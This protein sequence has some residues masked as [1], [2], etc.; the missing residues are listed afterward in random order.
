[1]RGRCCSRKAGGL[2]GGPPVA[3]SLLNTNSSDVKVGRTAREPPVAVSGQGRRWGISIMVLGHGMPQRSA[4]GRRRDPLHHLPSGPDPAELIRTSR[5]G[6]AWRLSAAGG[7]CGSAAAAGDARRGGIRRQERA[8]PTLRGP[9]AESGLQPGPTG[10]ALAPRKAAAAASQR[11]NSPNSLFGTRLSAVDE[12]L[13]RAKLS[14]NHHRQ[15]PRG[16]PADVTG[17]GQ[18]SS[19]PLPR[20]KRAPPLQETQRLWGARPRKFP[21]STLA[22]W[23]S[24]IRGAPFIIPG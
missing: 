23:N 24:R 9:S 16:T 15:P 2:L 17:P 14:P 10:L 20:I 12:I 1:M 8:A 11:P 3:K 21:R 7:D 6:R 19:T 18:W 13:T 22:G 5:D 4:P